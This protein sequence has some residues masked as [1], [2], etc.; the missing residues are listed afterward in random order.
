MSEMKSEG[1]QRL[2]M[3]YLLSSLLAEELVLT[4]RQKYHLPL[5]RHP[6]GEQL[7]AGQQQLWREQALT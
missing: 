4:L 5:R 2:D 7:G 1:E 3:N 6:R